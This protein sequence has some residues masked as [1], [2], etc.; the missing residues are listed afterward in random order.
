MIYIILTRNLRGYQITVNAHLF[1]CLTISSADEFGHS[2]TGSRISTIE[3]PNISTKVGSEKFSILS[4]STKYE[5]PKWLKRLRKISI[6]VTFFVTKKESLEQ[7][8]YG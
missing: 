5:N 7:S 8:K 2:S 4:N 6:F 1:T 3:I